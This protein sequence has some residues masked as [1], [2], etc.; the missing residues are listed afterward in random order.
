MGTPRKQRRKFTRPT[1]PWQI[2]RINAEKEI[3]V[4]FGLKNKTELWKA[5]SKLAR[6]R[7]QAKRLLAAKGERAD[8]ERA[9]L[10]EKIK[11]WGIKAS[12]LDDILAL[13]TEALLERRLQTVVV[14]RGIVPSAKQA[15]Q[16]IVHNHIYVGSHKI[17]VPGY[18]VLAK[19][20]DTVRLEDGI[21]VEQSVGKE[22]KEA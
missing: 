14:R 15:R 21:S 10:I 6:I 8:K 7:D 20:E 11:A 1:H 12:S 17:G 19:E 22:A 16:L 2:D 4:K 9:E 5:K 18:I 3:T 13:D